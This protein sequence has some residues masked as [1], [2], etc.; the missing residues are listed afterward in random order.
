S[1]SA[2]WACP[3]SVEQVEAG[4]GV[5]FE[6]SEDQEALQQAVRRLCVGAYP[7]A[8]VRSLEAH[9][10]VERGLWRRLADAGVFSLR[11]P[12]HAGGAGLGS[13]EAVLVFEQLGRSLV[14]GPLLWSHLGAG[15][16][17]GAAAGEQVV[18]G[19]ERGGRR[20]SQAPVV[21]EHLGALDRLLVLDESGVWAVEPG[22]V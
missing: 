17:D 13:C 11:L 19:V 12:E 3:G 15:M 2:S 10:G 21:V 14:P 4:R 22:A 5:D 18:G 8:T 16:V 7:M 9:G 1:A 6:L 20:G